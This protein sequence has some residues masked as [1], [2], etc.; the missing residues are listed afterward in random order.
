[1]HTC[2]HAYIGYN[3]L[4]GSKLRIARAFCGYLPAAK[5]LHEL[6]RDGEVGPTNNAVLPVG[7]VVSPQA[8][9]AR[10]REVSVYSC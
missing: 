10:K 2:I 5:A 8:P 7:T 9:H 6:E 1:M 3:L 4:D